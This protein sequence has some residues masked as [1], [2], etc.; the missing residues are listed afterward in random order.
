MAQYLGPYEEVTREY[1]AAVAS[2]IDEST[3]T[4]SLEVA[5]GEGEF[6]PTTQLS[7]DLASGVPLLYNNALEVMSAKWATLESGRIKLDGTYIWPDE[8]DSTEYW[9]A[10]FEPTA[11]AVFTLTQSSSMSGSGLSVVFDNEV[12][13]Y[14]EHIKVEF[15]TVD[16][17]SVWHTEEITDNDGPVVRIPYE[18]AGSGDIVVTVYADSW[19]GT[20][21]LKVASVYGGL[22]YDFQGGSILSF[23]VT[24]EASPFGS[25]LPT[26]QAT[27]VV[28]NSHGDFSVLSSNSIANELRQSM[29]I[30]VSIHIGGHAVIFDWLLYEWSENQAELS[31]TFVMRPAVGFERRFT[32]VSTGTEL[33]FNLINETTGDT[34][35]D[36]YGYDDGSEVWP[37]MNISGN[38]Y[39]GEDQQADSALQQLANGISCYWDVL[40]EPNRI[41]LVKPS[42]LGNV[43]HITPSAQLTAPQLTQ[44][45][46]IK[47]IQVQW[48][49]WENGE[50]TNYTYTEEL[51]SEAGEDVT[52][53]APNVMSEAQAASVASNAGSFYVNRVTMTCEIKGD[54]ALHP[55]QWVGL[56]ILDPATGETNGVQ[57]LLTKVQTTFSDDILKTNIEGVTQV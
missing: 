41:V 35:L 43:R 18:F 29:P 40:R 7:G 28:D 17:S 32:T 24:E 49:K 42:A 56:D 57:V 8:N 45:T 39:I 1:M 34:A 47:N 38:E 51:D 25:S 20:H 9:G 13:E 53:Y 36:W 50:L 19:V 5:P 10:W 3:I 52:I 27:L 55:L 26:P 31:A 6:Y 23:E 16:G 46:M 37:W 11:D 4:A 22:L 21:Y 54:P 30:S 14:A 44:Q 2:S 33:F 48:A 15:Y 12:G